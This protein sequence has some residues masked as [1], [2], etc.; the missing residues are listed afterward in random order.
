MNPV[1]T[2]ATMQISPRARGISAIGES[3]RNPHSAARLN[4]GGTSGV[5]SVAMAAPHAWQKCASATNPVPHSAHNFS[6]DKASA[7][8]EATAGFQKSWREAGAGFQ[9]S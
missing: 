2:A 5:D 1:T 4:H 7:G 3:P 8:E 9:N 6:G